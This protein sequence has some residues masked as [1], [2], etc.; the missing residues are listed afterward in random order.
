MKLPS[1]LG[2]GHSRFSGGATMAKGGTLNIPEMCPERNSDLRIEFKIQADLPFRAL[3]HWDFDHTVTDGQYSRP[4][5]RLP[6]LRPTGPL[7]A[8]G[9]TPRLVWRTYSLRGCP[10][11]PELRHVE[12]RQSLPDIRFALARGAHVG[13]LVIVPE[14]RQSQ[15][16]YNLISRDQLHTTYGSRVWKPWADTATQKYLA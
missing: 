7:R 16:R 1:I 2:D 10:G 9:R 3:L 12:L 4:T 5:A 8:A 11:L 15:W 13:G 14:T 6:S